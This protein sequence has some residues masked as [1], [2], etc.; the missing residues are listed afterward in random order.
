VSIEPTRLRLREYESHLA[1]N[2]TEIGAFKARQ[3]A[4]FEAERQRWLEAGQSVASGPNDA[5]SEP[6]PQ[7]ALAPGST[8]VESPVAG[9]VWKIHASVGAK[10]RGGDTIVVVESMKME[11]PVEAPHD[12]R[13]V[14][15][16]VSEGQSVSPGQRI[17]VI[18]SA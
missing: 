8:E 12:G 15:I 3:Q 2:A 14:D 5:P 11:V 16:V 13:V 9:S 18:A 17:A 7:I 1:E 6:V 10:V 4:A